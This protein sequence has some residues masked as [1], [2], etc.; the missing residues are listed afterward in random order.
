MIVIVIH[1]DERH[2]RKTCFSKR[3]KYK[4]AKWCLHTPVRV[5]KKGEI[6]DPTVR[7]VDVRNST[8]RCDLKVAPRGT[9]ALAGGVHLCRGGHVDAA[10]ER[11]QHFKL[12]GGDHRST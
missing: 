1:N 4:R 6:R 8:H 5:L 9:G 11:I 7:E 12:A 10:L 3:V 2:I